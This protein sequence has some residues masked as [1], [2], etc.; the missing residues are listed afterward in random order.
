MVHLRNMVL[1]TKKIMENCSDIL[2]IHIHTH[3][4]IISFTL[5]LIFRFFFFFN[6]E[7]QHKVT[8][9]REEAM[10]SS[11][12][13]KPTLYGGSQSESQ[14][15]LEKSQGGSPYKIRLYEQ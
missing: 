7:N 3:M 4:Y 11:F 15:D 6:Q 5:Y 12:W 13:Y 2:G 9:H 10:K 14:G 1:T 8:P